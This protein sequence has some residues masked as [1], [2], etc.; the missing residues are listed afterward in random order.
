MAY[1]TPDDVE[2]YININ[3]VPDINSVIAGAQRQID[4]YT[5]DIFESTVTSVYAE[6]N[7]AY[8]AEL[9]YTTQSVDS[10]AALPNN[11][12]LDPSTYS[13]ENF[14]RPVIRLFSTVPWSILV[15]GLE[16][17]N[18]D[19][20]SNIRLEVSGTFGYAQTPFQIQNATALLAA[21]YIS[22][23]G[24]GELKEKALEI[25]GQPS[26]VESVDVEGYSVSFFQESVND[27][28]KSTGVVG[29]D[30][31]IAPFVRKRRTKAE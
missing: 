22:L 7:R 12:V 20:T 30:R 23:A 11:I 1:C 5:N 8:F 3:Q 13:F 21:Y 15:A 24:Q 28:T 27:L 4:L 29:I 31:F 26:N 2:L 14:K 16:P 6:S 18:N 19:L 9:P 17:W 10:V 25:I